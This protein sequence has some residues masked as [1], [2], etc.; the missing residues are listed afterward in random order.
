MS[1]NPY[2]T[3]VEG[4]PVQSSNA[5]DR[6]YVPGI[7]LVISGIVGLVCNVGGGLV[8][9]GVYLGAQEVVMEEF[10]KDPDQVENL[11]EEE[12]RGVMNLLGYGGLVA[13]AGGLVGILIV[14][15][16]VQMIRVR[17]WVIALLGAL[18]S[19]VPCVQGCFILGV[20]IGIW[21]LVVLMDSS[22]KQ[23]FK[24]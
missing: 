6:C 1:Y 12:A 2:S 13:A 3:G 17:G 15:G 5:K 19:M 23:A 20:P 21:C 14:I 11:T 9:A 16:G 24:L 7:L 22:V 4:A 8:T 18:L 10:R